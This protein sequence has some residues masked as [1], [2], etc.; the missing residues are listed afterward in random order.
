MNTITYIHNIHQHLYAHVLIFR[1]LNS[2]IINITTRYH[3]VCS[4]YFVN[5]DTWLNYF[6][7]GFNDQQL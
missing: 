2:S 4:S 3:Q 6:Q 5:N 7:I 1:C